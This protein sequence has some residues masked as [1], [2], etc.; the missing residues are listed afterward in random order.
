MNVFH[1]GRSLRDG[2]GIAARALTFASGRTSLFLAAGGDMK[3][4]VKRASLGTVRGS[5][6]SL[7]DG[8]SAGSDDDLQQH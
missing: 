6:T 8:T 4:G 7:S 3:A 1:V 2:V 5:T